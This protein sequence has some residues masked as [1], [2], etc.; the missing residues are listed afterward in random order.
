MAQSIRAL[1]L[2]CVRRHPGRASPAVVALVSGRGV[3]RRRSQ[4]FL[5]S[6]GLDVAA[7]GW[8]R[9]H[10]GGSTIAGDKRRR[11]RDGGGTE[12]APGA[13][14]C[15]TAAATF[16]C[17]CIPLREESMATLENRGGAGMAEEIAWK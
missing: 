16:C 17:C 5:S 6:H 4:G 1:A 14:V 7:G 11:H 8:R 15:R 2:Q 12:D 10:H 3:K 9:G 13:R